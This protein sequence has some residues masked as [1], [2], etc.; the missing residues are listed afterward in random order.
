MRSLAHPALTMPSCSGAWAILA[1]TEFPDML[2][3]VFM[4]SRY[5]APCWTRLEN[6]ALEFV[7]T[8]RRNILKHWKA[9]NVGMLA[10]KPPSG[11]VVGQDR[12]GL[13]SAAF[14]SPPGAVRG[15]SHDI[16]HAGRNCCCKYPAI[17]CSFLTSPTAIA[18]IINFQPMH[19]WRRLDVS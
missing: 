12:Q 11:L 5:S 19:C 1:R 10:K 14:T 4:L 17:C 15:R 18:C 16:R 7:E 6:K 8:W 3:V 9:K 13:R 2:N